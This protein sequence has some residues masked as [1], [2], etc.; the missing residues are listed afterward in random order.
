[1]EKQC[2]HCQAIFKAKRIDTVYCSHSCKQMAY[3]DRKFGSSLNGSINNQGKEPLIQSQPSIIKL[4]KPVYPSIDVSEQQNNKTSIDVSD[5]TSKISKEPFETVNYRDDLTD[6]FK[7]RIHE[8]YVFVKSSFINSLEELRV[9]RNLENSI[10]TVWFRS[11]EAVWISIRYKCIAE[12][13]LTLSDMECIMPEDLMELCN[14]LTYLTKSRNFDYL[15]NSFPYTREILNL[16]K[17]LRETCKRLEEDVPFKFR[18]KTKTKLELI[19]GRSELSFIAPKRSFS[20]L[21]FED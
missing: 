14:A 17:S 9:N 2:E 3:M 4:G 6:K 12:C 8:P 13:L 10:E 16:N 11:A 5:K 19:I 20:Q 21:T 18:L 7:E 1:M 15:S